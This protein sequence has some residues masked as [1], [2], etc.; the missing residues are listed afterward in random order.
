MKYKLF[1]FDADDTVLDF[2]GAERVALRDTLTR[3]QVPGGFDVFYP[4]YREVSGVLWKR[5]EDGEINQNFLKVERFRETLQKLHAEGNPAL[6]NEDYM[7]GL[8]RIDM[9]MEGAD[10]LCRFL[11]PLGEI[12]IAT[13]GI[14]EVQSRRILTSSLG[15]YFSFNA[16]SESCGFSKPDVRF[17]EY[18]AT[19][20]KPFKKEQALMVG[21]READIRGA[22][23]FGIDSCYFNPLGRPLSADLSPKF[24]IRR[25]T[26]LIPLLKN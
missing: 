23:N 17:F 3:F 14:F 21:D 2:R 19:L 20:A 9:P 16:I 18:A 7:D 15:K 11:Q 8:C 22:E 6:M 12:G 10:E 1:L 4:A 25:L 26:D 13:N 24:E 5:L